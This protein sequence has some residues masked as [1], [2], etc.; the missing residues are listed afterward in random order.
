MWSSIVGSEIR[1][2]DH[3]DVGLVIKNVIIQID[4]MFFLIFHVNMDCILL[5]LWP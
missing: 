1:S 5:Y 4:L 3:K 2:C